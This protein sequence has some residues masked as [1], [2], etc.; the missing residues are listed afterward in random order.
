MEARGQAP[1]N[2]GG[3]GL[4]LAESP[5]TIAVQ[6][7]TLPGPECSGAALARGVIYPVPAVFNMRKNSLI[8]SAG[9][10]GGGGLNIYGALRCGKIYS[11]FLPMPGRNWTMQFCAQ[12]APDQPASAQDA[13]VAHFGEGLVPP[14]A[15]S[16]FDFQRL[17]L[18]PNKLGKLII[19]K[20]LLRTDGLIDELQVY[21]SVLP[22]MDDNARLAFSQWKFKPALREGKPVAVQ[23]LVGIPADLPVP[24]PA[25]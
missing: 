15:E 24:P 21:Q 6:G 1:T 13:T 2:T 16:K 4:S 18:P 11:I 10:N 14:Q 9:P 20:G 12:T 19:L 5:I 3:G 17:Q 8:V 22:E 23:V 25:Q 7:T